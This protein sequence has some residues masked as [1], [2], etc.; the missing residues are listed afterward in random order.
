MFHRN[1]WCMRL[2]KNCV[3]VNRKNILFLSV[4]IMCSDWC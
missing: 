4:N 1:E 2:G 3:A